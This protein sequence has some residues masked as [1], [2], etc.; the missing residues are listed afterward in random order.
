MLLL[1]GEKIDG[2]T[3]STRVT[4][5]KLRE[6][7]DD[8]P[9]PVTFSIAPD[10]AG[11]PAIHVS[12]V[13]DDDDRPLEQRIVEQLHM[14]PKTKNAL[15][16]ALSRNNNDVEAAITNLFEAKAIR[17]TSVQVRGK[18]TKAFELRR[19]GAGNGARKVAGLWPDS[20]GPE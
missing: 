3:V 7:P 5:A 6:E 2:R 17:T 16:T 9:L 14:G 19:D 20:G 11:E 10:A 4:F 13:R 18:D 1:K 8:Y 12:C 15:K